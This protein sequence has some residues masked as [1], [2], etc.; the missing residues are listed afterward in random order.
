MGLQI[1]DT[2]TEDALTLTGALPTPNDAWGF[3]VAG[4]YV[5]IA[6]R[7]AGMIIADVS[8]PQKAELLAQ[9]DTDGATNDIIIENTVAY[10]ADGLNGLVVVDVNSPATPFWLTEYAL[11][12]DGTGRS[13]DGGSFSR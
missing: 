1:F 8:N 2:S 10:L 3:R 11:P 6:D 9:L 13:S 5:Y 7:L 12:N 4:D